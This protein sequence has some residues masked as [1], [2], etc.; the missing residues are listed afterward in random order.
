MRN[1][2]ELSELLND[3][4]VEIFNKHSEM[5]I[6]LKTDNLAEP[7]KYALSQGGK[8]LR[9]LLMLLS[10]EIN[11]GDIEDAI[12]PA[13][14]L[15][16]FHNFTLL[17]DDIMDEAPM[18]RGMP[19]VYQRWNTNTAILAGDTMFAL[20]V[21]FIAHTHADHVQPLL[22]QFS[23]TSVEVCEGQQLDMDYEKYES[24]PTNQYIEMIRLKTAV[25]LA[26]ALKIG[27]MIAYVP[28][29]AQLA[30]Y[31]YGEAIGLAFQLMDD[32]LDVY[33][34]P[35][36]FGKNIGGDIACGK[37]TFLYTKTMEIADVTTKQQL[38]EIY[39]SNIPDKFTKTIDIF[40]SINIKEETLNAIDNY[41][42]VAENYLKEADLSQEAMTI[43]REFCNKLFIRTV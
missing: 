14:G 38:L 42:S 17:H 37:K 22:N 39:N 6:A 40:N 4:F 35:K 34:D 33:G 10:C 24:I 11:G 3:R 8:R 28:Q 21:R 19:T 41:H 13:I 23:I 30:L 7:I 27:A 29:P 18:R 9:P 31:K 15:E 16:I 2:E 36:V 1:Y 26:S 20:A 5:S 32:Y 12:Y 25:M 43:L